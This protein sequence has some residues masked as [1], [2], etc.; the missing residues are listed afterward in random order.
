MSRRKR[1]GQSDKKRFLSFSFARED[2]LLCNKR[3][4]DEQKRALDENEDSAWRLNALREELVCLN[5]RG[6]VQSYA[7]GRVFFEA[8]QVRRLEK[9][10]RNIPIW[11][12]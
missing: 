5:E 8:E 4:K 11:I 9:R 3:D 12:L 1:Q 10:A 6:V 2:F 7:D